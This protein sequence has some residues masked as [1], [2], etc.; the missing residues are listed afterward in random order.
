MGETL[1]WGEARC[2][3]RTATT[4]TTTTAD[5]GNN[6]GRIVGKNTTKR[7]HGVEMVRHKG[8]CIQISGSFS[9]ETR[10]SQN[11]RWIIRV[12]D[13]RFY[14]I[15]TP[16]NKAAGRSLQWRRPRVATIAQ[17]NATLKSRF[18]LFCTL[19]CNTIFIDAVLAVNSINVFCF[20]FY[21]VTLM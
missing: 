11:G 20:C 8:R 14:S 15:V 2:L 17:Q 13:G 1:L 7:Q 4:T 21:H 5:T 9:H 19:F 18:C 10:V 6:A 12:V 16:V 3:Y